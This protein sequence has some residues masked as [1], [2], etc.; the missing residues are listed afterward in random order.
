MVRADVLAPARGRRALR[1]GSGR[2][3]S[4]DVFPVAFPVAVPADPGAFLP[5]V[6]AAG[7]LAGAVR[8]DA[9]LPEP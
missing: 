3:R 4:V 7:R 6:G 8:G 1:A 5:L 2:R 9:L